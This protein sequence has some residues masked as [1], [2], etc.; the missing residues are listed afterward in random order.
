[1]KCAIARIGQA[2]IYID[3]I[4]ASAQ[5]VFVIPSEMNLHGKINL[6]QESGRNNKWLDPK[7]EL[8]P[9]LK[10]RMFLVT[11]TP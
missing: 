8:M 1:M 5:N 2:C 6:R 10:I 7:K 4:Y 3:M 9:R 11:S